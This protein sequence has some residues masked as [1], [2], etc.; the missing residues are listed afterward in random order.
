MVEV[1]NKAKLHGP[2]LTARV[3]VQEEQ[4]GTDRK[5]AEEDTST[6]PDKIVEDTTRLEQLVNDNTVRGGEEE[7]NEAPNLP[8]CKEAQYILDDDV[9][10][11]CTVQISELDDSQ[12]PEGVKRKVDEALECERKLRLPRCA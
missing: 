11:I 5:V 4:V 8:K 1:A 7:Q 2:L 9:K 6:K 10:S 3:K 12:L